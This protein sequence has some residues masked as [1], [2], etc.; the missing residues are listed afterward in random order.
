ML[1]AKEIIYFKQTQSATTEVIATVACIFRI[2]AMSSLPTPFIP[3][4]SNDAYPKKY[5]RLCNNRYVYTIAWRV[6][7]CIWHI[8]S[9]LLQFVELCV[10]SASENKECVTQLCVFSSFFPVWKRQTDGETMN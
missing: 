10:C 4:L 8:S 1:Y 6:T 9:Y 2:H 7:V 5:Y 3:P